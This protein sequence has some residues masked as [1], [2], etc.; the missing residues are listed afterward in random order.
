MGAGGNDMSC[1]EANSGRDE[2]GWTEGVP[3]RGTD[4][5]FPQTAIGKGPSR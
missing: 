2:D 1:L 3:R 4:G 5:G